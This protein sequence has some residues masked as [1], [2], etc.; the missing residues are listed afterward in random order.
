M[1]KVKKTE[2]MVEPYYQDDEKKW[3]DTAGNS[4]YTEKD[5]KLAMERE[6]LER[7]DRGINTLRPADG[8]AIII[9]IFGLFILGGMATL[10]LNRNPLLAI[11]CG[12]GFVVGMYVFFKFFM[13]TMPSFRTKVYLALIA[14]LLISNFV[15]SKYFGIHIL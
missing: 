12:I 11:T 5:A 9:A 13:H 2:S 15:L 7:E 8:I 14:L 6:V 3:K 4:S 10:G 1:R